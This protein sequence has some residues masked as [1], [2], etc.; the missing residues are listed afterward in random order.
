MVG[1]MLAGPR[2]FLDFRLGLRDRLS[3]LECHGARKRVAA[4]AQVSGQGTH[5]NAALLDRSRAPLFERACRALEPAG[6]FRR[7]VERERLERLAGRGI[8]RANRSGIV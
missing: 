1:E 6:D 8:D 2:A 4:G 5:A 7:A 3:H